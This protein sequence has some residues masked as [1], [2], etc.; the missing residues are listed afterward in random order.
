MYHRTPPGL[1]RDIA[2]HAAQRLLPDQVI[3]DQ[4]SNLSTPADP[5]V[6]ADVVRE[7]EDPAVAAIT[8]VGQVLRQ[9]WR[10]SSLVECLN[11][12]ARMQQPRHRR[13]TPGLLALK[14]LYWN[15]RTFATGR[16][17]QTPYGLLGVPLPT[18]DWWELLRMPPEQLP[19]QLPAPRAAA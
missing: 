15:C 2:S 17:R 12:V 13:M 9:A 19:Q 6:W 5:P 14:R 16:H 3:A 7:D 10:A 1:P 4:P 11:S 18:R 8:Q